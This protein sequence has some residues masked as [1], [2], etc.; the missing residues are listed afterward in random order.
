MNAVS[1]NRLDV[2]IHKGVPEATYHADP[3]I[4]P[5]ASSGVLRT[6]VQRSPEH[7][8][9]THPRLN[10]VRKD[11]SSTEAM[12]RGTILHALVL[13]TPHPHRVLHVADYRSAAARDQRDAALAAGLIPVKADDMEELED[14]ASAIRSRL[15]ALPEVWSAMQAAISEGMSEATLIWQERGVLCRCRYDTLPPATYRATY[16]LKF[17]GLS[18]EPDA[19]GK[20]VT[21][22]YAFQADLYPR[23]VRALRG[24]RPLF[25]FLAAETEAPYGVSLHALD[26]EA[27]DLARQKVDAALAQWAECLRSGEWP[28]YP[29][30]VHFHGAKPWELTAWDNR[31]ER[32]RVVH[33]LTGNPGLASEQRA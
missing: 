26:P 6:L 5:S 20:K 11:K 16:D 22:D 33:G 23:A 1:P 17:T 13:N 15:L 3:A 19:F 9:M 4:T 7:A 24:D 18:A 28:S 12:N 25:V 27:A 29:P 14:V 21:G 32:E 30:L 10:M 2:G 8:W 31:Q